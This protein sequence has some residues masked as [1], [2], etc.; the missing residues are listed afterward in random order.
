SQRGTGN[1]YQGDLAFQSSFANWDKFSFPEKSRSV[2]AFYLQE[3]WQPVHFFNLVGGIR[4]DRYS[5]FGEAVNPR[6]ALLFFPWIDVDIKVQFATSFRA[7][8]FK[9]LYDETDIEFLGNPDLEPEK[10]RTFEAGIGFAFAPKSFFRLNAYKNKIT[11]S[12]GLEQGASV[13]SSVQPRRYQNKEGQSIVG[14]EAEARFSYHQ[15]SYLYGNASIFNAKDLGSSSWLTRVPQ[16]RA[17]VRLNQQLPWNTSVNISIIYGG[18]RITNTLDED[19][20]FVLGRIQ[21]ASPYGLVNLA[22]N[23][24]NILNTGMGVKLSIFNLFNRDYREVVRD[25]RMV[26]SERSDIDARIPTNQRS[27]FIE[28]YIGI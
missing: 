26:L 22:V 16:F 6:V 2:V 10:I 14:A 27:Y 19:N 9:E 12:I 5:D 25:H 1:I 23:R 17:N 18:K 13:T 20:D 4:F 7:P 24:K 8:T 15:G 3:D 11:D 21:R 28:A